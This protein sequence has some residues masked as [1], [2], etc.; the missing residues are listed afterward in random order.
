M[1]S[2]FVMIKQ[3]YRGVEFRFNDLKECQDVIELLADKGIDPTTF[4]ITVNNDEED[5]DEDN[6]IAPGDNFK[7]R[8]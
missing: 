7:G 4:S 1:I 8:G 2:Y 5:E 6:K 3:D